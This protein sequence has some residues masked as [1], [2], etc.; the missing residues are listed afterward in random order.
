MI[1]VRLTVAQAEWLLCL[2]REHRNYFIGVDDENKTIKYYLLMETETFRHGDAYAI[3]KLLF[4]CDWRWFMWLW[5]Y[6]H[7]KVIIPMVKDNP[8]L[9][10]QLNE[11]IKDM[12]SCLKWVRLE[13][14]YF[15]LIKLIKYYNDQFDYRTT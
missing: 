14:A 10:R 7:R 8:H 15:T 4:H 5:N 13:A 9:R 1:K 11:Q 12:K 3:D 2:L 6:L